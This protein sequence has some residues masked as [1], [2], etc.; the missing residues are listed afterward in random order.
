M[1]ATQMTNDTITEYEIVALDTLASAVQDLRRAQQ[2]ADQFTYKVGGG[3]Y[4]YHLRRLLQVSQHLDALVEN[5][6]NTG[7]S[8]RIGTDLFTR[9]LDGETLRQA[10]YEEQGVPVWVRS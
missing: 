2:V 5:A 7:L 8:A 10:D 6:Q 9:V 3:T 4:T 1:T